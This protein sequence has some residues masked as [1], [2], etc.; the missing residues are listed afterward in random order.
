[1]FRSR[2]IRR[3]TLLA[4]AVA[5]GGGLS[6]GVL[7]C[8]HGGFAMGAMLDALPRGHVAIAFGD[9]PLYFHDGYFLRPRGGGF[10]VIQA[11]LGATVSRL[12]RGATWVRLDGVRHAVYRNVYYQPQFRGRNTAYVVVRLRE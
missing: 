10:V 8:A 1:M 4:A 12:P 2:R 3:G 11:P 5:L 9:S 6:V 7:G